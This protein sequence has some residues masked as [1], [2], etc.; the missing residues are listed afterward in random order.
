MKKF[1][2]LIFL[3][4]ALLFGCLSTKYTTKYIKEYSEDQRSELIKDLYDGMWV[5]E[6]DSIPLEDWLETQIETKNGYEIQR[7]FLI[8]DSINHK[9]M[10]LF[11]THVESDTTY[12]SLEVLESKR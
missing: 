1:L 9:F 8:K 11:N 3:T 10:I 5:F 2:V 12:Y 4:F 6:F 7:S